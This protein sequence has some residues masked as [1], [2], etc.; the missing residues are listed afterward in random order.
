MT[1]RGPM[2]SSVLDHCELHFELGLHAREQERDRGAVPV[3]ADVAKDDGRA[4]LGRQPDD[5]R[6]VGERVDHLEADG[7]KARLGAKKDRAR[8]IERADARAARG[9]DLGRISE[10]A[11][12]LEDDVGVVDLRFCRRAEIGGLSAEQQRPAAAR[13]HGRELGDARVDDFA[14][15]RPFSE[16]QRRA[17]GTR[18]IRGNL[19]ICLLPSATHACGTTSQFNSAETNLSCAYMGTA[20]FLNKKSC[21]HP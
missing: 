9:Y 3:A 19:S 1:E 20:A 7:G 16:P 17:S 2:Q 6:E 11:P 14:S 5:A 8:D 21:V 18:R 12:N 13:D 10:G 15:A 4:Q